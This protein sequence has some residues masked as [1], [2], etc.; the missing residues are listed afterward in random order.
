MIVALVT[1][2][3]ALQVFKS[4][5][6][7]SGK[8]SDIQKLSKVA[9]GA[10][11]ICTASS[12]VEQVPLGES[13]YINFKQVDTVVMENGNKLVATSEDGDFSR[14]F[15]LGSCLY[16]FNTNPGDGEVSTDESSAWRFTVATKGG[17]SGTLDKICI[18]ACAEGSCEDFSP[19]SDG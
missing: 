10:R 13:A 4:P 3:V 12:D 6:N 9:S 5:L 16:E 17:D 18:N 15:Q 19:C 1:I 11:E 7:Q 8:E 2:T 14:E